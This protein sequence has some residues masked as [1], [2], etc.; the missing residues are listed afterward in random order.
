MG[1]A[2]ERNPQNLERKAAGTEPDSRPTRAGGESAGGIPAGEVRDLMRRGIQEHQAGRLP[3]AIA[4][5]R[6]VLDAEPD[7]ADA[8]HLLGVLAHQMG[9]AENAVRLITSAVRKNP[10]VAGY[11]GN[12]GYAL[13]GLGRLDDAIAS[14]REALRL[15]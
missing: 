1:K 8:N 5:Y 11:H 7:H 6:R 13:H 9:E 2:D 14:Y 12:L 10:A 4:V 3:E 15:D